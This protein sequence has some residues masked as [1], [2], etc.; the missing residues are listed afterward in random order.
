MEAEPV[1][2]ADRREG[3][4]LEYLQELDL[5]RDSNVADLVQKDGAVRSAAA[6]DAGIVLDG[7]S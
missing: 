6:E 5:H 7:A 4:L 2:A 1:V 3:A